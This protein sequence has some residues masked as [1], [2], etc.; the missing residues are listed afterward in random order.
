VI[1]GE[2]VKFTIICLNKRQHDQS[3]AAKCSASLGTN[4]RFWHE[5]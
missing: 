4:F 3:A 2:M 1:G 5:V